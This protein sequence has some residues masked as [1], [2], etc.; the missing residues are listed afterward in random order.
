VLKG[1]GRFILGMRARVI[2][3]S[4][5]LRMLDPWQGKMRFFF[6]MEL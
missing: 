2:A 5:N 1:K 4:A 3:L 6:E